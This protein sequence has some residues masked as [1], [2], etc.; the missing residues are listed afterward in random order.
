[1]L[2]RER[3]HEEQL[4]LGCQLGEPEAFRELVSL[5]EPRLLYYLR[6]FLPEEADAWDVLQEV[7]LQVVRQI[8]HLR[9]PAAVRGW[10]Y[11]I[12][13][14]A[15]LARRRHQAAQIHS[16]QV[17]A[18]ELPLAE[19]PDDFRAADLHRLLARLT[20]PQREVVTLYFVEA[21]SYEEIATATDSP[22]GTVKSRLYY[23][24]RSLRQWLEADHA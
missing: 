16:E 3:I 13:H 22:V 21:M 7:W 17:Y 11:R 8:R 24:K 20:E 18:G 23:A 19:E 10:I 4:V 9:Q 5:L 14:N 1:M 15:M 2:D 12:A 6:R